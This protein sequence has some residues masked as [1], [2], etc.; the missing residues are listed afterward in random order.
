MR[1]APGW[2]DVIGAKMLSHSWAGEC[3]VPLWA[4]GRRAERGE[5]EKDQEERTMKKLG[6]WVVEVGI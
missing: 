5:N 4:N 6:R 2:F 1:V 3:D